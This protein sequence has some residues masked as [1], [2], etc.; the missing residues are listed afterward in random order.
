MVAI[1]KAARQNDRGVTLFWEFVP[2]PDEVDWA[3]DRRIERSDG[4]SL[5]VGPREL[6]YG[7]AGRASRHPNSVGA[8]GGRLWFS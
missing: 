4:L 6:D 1:R 2:V 3:T 8:A 7:D 5:A